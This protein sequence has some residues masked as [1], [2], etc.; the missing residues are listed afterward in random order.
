MVSLARNKVIVIRLISF[1]LER[2]FYVGLGGTKL[3]TQLTP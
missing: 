2:P 3:Q 1:W